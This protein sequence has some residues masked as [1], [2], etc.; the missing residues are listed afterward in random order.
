MVVF[1]DFGRWRFL[2]Q[3]GWQDQNVVSVYCGRCQFVGAG[4]GSWWRR[5]AAVVADNDRNFCMGCRYFYV[6]IWL[7]LRGRGQRLRVGSG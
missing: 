7:E 4:D 6:A 5:S 3:D 2:C 1:R